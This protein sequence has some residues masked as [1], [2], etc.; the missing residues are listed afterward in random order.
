MTGAANPVARLVDHVVG[1]TYEA[2]PSSVVQA[3][4]IF[5]LDTFSCALAGTTGPSADEVVSATRSW[6]QGDDAGVWGRS[7]RL[8]G[9]SAALVNAYHIH[10]LEFDCVHEGGVLHP[11]SSLMAALMAETERHTARGGKPVTGKEFIAAVAAGIDVSCSIAVASK[12]PM[13]FFRPASVGG[14]GSTAACAKIRGFTRDQTWNALGVMYGQTSGTMQAH[15]EGSKLLGLQVGFAARGAVASCDLVA[16]GVEGPKDILTGV[17]GYLPLFEGAYDIE[18]AWSQF[19]KVYRL[20]EI[21]HKPFPS[22]RLTHYAVDALQRLQAA[23]GFKADDVANVVCR[24]P[25]L[26]KRLVGRPDIADPLPNYAKLCLGYV[27]ATALIKGTVDQFDFL[28]DALKRADVHALAARVEVIEDGNPDPNAFGPQT[29]IV[30]LKNGDQHE[31]TITAAIGDPKNRFP[32]DR[33]IEKFWRC[34]NSTPQPLPQDN[35]QRLIEMIDSLERVPDMTALVRMMT[36]P[37]GAV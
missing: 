36:P 12:A 11:M 18:P 26:P 22:G 5:I 21:G 31:I 4:K 30:T 37:P 6:G 14:F 9:P 1:T 24:V 8:P 29:I 2:L 17:W 15:V 3:A 23:H 13:R 27:C 20:T 25:P 28:P 34:W 35:G 19:G 33:Q 32:R 10:C 16:A 7:L